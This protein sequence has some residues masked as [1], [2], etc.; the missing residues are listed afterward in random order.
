MVVIFGKWYIFL[1]YFVKHLRG[2]FVKDVKG[3]FT[4]IVFRVEILFA[5]CVFYYVNTRK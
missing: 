4:E 2:K 5:I 1:E 3:N